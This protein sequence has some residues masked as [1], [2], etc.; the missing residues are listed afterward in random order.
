MDRDRVHQ[1]IDL[2]FESIET[3]P[4]TEFAPHIEPAETAIGAT[5]PDDVLYVACALGCEAGIWSDDSDFGQQDLVP[6]F[7]TRDVIESFGA[8]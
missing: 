5:D 4:E 7:T 1:V 8:G 6:V 2:L 3:V